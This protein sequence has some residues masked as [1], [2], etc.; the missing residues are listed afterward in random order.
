VQF[1]I[2]LIHSLITVT[3]PVPVI[4]LAGGVAAD[5]T[6]VRTDFVNQVKQLTQPKTVSVADTAIGQ[7]VDVL[8]DGYELANLVAVAVADPAISAGGQVHLGHE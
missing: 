4:G 8:I 3:L 5:V 1:R 6:N 2:T 7:N